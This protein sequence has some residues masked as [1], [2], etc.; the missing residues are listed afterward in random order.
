MYF[1]DDILVNVNISAGTLTLIA[2]P[3]DTI[4]DIKAKIEDETGISYYYQRL[5]LAGKL[6]EDSYILSS[7]AQLTLDLETILCG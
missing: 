2:K 7:S 5:K 6:L 4:R 1:I 3:L